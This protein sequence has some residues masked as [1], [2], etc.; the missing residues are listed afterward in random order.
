MFS[1]KSLRILIIDDNFDIHADFKKAL[2]DN[3]D[4]KDDKDEDEVALF[5]DRLNM[6]ELCTYQIDSAFQGQEALELVKNSMSNRKHYALAFVD[7][8]MPPGWDGIET[9]QKI[10]EID[11]EIQM[12][13]VSAYSDYSWED[14]IRVLGKT[15][16]LLILKKPFETMEIRQ[17]ALALTRK[18]AL[19][20]E[21][22]FQIE[23]LNLLVEERTI[24]LKNSLSMTDA[25]LEGILEGIL[26]IGRNKSIL[27]Y[28][29]KFLKIFRLSEE[30]T[31]ST[32]SGEI[33]VRVAEQVENPAE[34]LE[35][36]DSIE[37]TFNLKEFS[38]LKL[39]SNGILQ[40]YQHP[41]ML[42]DEVVGVVFS[43]L[44]ISENRRDIKRSSASGY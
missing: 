2:H 42:N 43:F 35:L 26:V 33:L 30:F 16:N 36:L 39:K 37:N 8:K 40:V 5:G 23:N 1:D 7:I 15:E 21:V 31:Q 12:V 41:Q 11:P 20:R 18:W 27:K 14:I 22:D 38:E 9:I 17:L 6:Q 4:D 13:I 24:D 19:K 44:D 29:Q 34:F 32:S 10:W 25:T 3:K 28:N